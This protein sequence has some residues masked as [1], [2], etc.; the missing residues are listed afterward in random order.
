MLTEREAYAAWKDQR[1]VKVNGAL[2]WIVIPFNRLFDIGEGQMRPYGN[3]AFV[4]QNDD[5]MV[6]IAVLEDMELE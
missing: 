4:V 5:N 3:V 1:R 6:H 2:C